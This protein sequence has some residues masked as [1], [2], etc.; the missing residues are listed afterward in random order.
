MASILED[1]LT[2]EEIEELKQKH[3]A[4]GAVLTAAGPVVLRRCT[5]AEY[6]RF[7]AQSAGDKIVAQE[8]LSK[9]CTLRPDA[10][11]L[12]AWFESYPAISG[13]TGTLVLELAGLEVEPETKKF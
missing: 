12:E 11:T 5:R 6:K 10:K 2:A 9:A 7:V 3:G 1:V 8:N 4:L 13:A